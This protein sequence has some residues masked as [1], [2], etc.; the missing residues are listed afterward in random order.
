MKALIIYESFFGNTEKIAQAI[1][2]GLGTS[3]EVE[4]CKV[5][6]VKPEHLESV[7]LLIVGSA[8]RAF[9]PSPETKRF[10]AHLPAKSL[11]GKKAAAFDTR[12]SLKDIKVR[13][14]RFLVNLFGYAAKPISKK[15]RKK[16]AEIVTAPEGFLVKD[17]EGPL[18]EGEL[19]RAKEWAKKI[20][21]K[22]LSYFQSDY[23]IQG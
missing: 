4:I 1:G 3:T 20:K 22:K 15:L 14:L 18:K 23:I 11:Q 6:D 8:T 2:E 9:S 17:T 7:D 5:G 21:I 19:E 13:I 10:L 12:I 16:G